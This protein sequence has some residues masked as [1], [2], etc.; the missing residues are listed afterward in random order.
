MILSI[1]SHTCKPQILETEAGGS[2]IQSQSQL[3]NNFEANMGHIE[4]PCLKTKEE[5]K[6]T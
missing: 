2:W 5:N 6:L 3:C 4:R 1:A